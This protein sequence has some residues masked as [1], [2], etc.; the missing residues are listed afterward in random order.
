[1]RGERWR[2]TEG[3]RGG[4]GGARESQFLPIGQG[5]GAVASLRQSR[6]RE[7]GDGPSRPMWPSPHTTQADSNLAKPR[8]NELEPREVSE[9]RRLGPFSRPWAWAWAWPARLTRR[10][11]LPATVR[12]EAT[13]PGY[14]LLTPLPKPCQ[15]G[16]RSG[17][18]ER[19]FWGEMSHI[20]PGQGAGFCA[21]SE[22][23]QRATTQG[24][25]LGRAGGPRGERW[26]WRR[27]R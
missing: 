19:L 22:E 16:S 21:A 18:R 10:G 13:E 4:R 1:M 11:G 15:V 26:R 9:R 25:R 23:V 17:E 27:R 7:V 14:L 12:R 8:A 2:G 3:G 24:P 5:A 6:V 20:G